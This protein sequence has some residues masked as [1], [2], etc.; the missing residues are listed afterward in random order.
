M[1]FNGNIPSGNLLH[2][3]LERSTMLFMGKSTIS[4][5]PYSIAMLNY[6]RVIFKYIP[7]MTHVCCFWYI[8][9]KSGHCFCSPWLH[10]GHCS[11]RHQNTWQWHSFQML[12]ATQ[13]M[14][15]LGGDFPEIGSK[16][17]GNLRKKLKTWGRRTMEKPWLQTDLLYFS[18]FSEKNP[19]LSH[20]R[21]PKAE[22]SSG[23]GFHQC[24]ALVVFRQNEDALIHVDTKQ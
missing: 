23:P 1:G 20:W 18:Q 13:H 9:H 4:T 14:L 10:D 22:T 8:C 16:T 11:G 12:P 24:W 19:P 2:S 21:H 3:E 15:Y 5:G 17:V 6:Q 7:I